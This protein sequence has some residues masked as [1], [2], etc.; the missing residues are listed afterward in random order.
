VSKA[1]GRSTLELF[2]LYFNLKN[3]ELKPHIIIGDNNQGIKTVA[4]NEFSI[5]YV[6]VGSAE[7]AIR[8]KSPI[9]LLPINRIV[10]ST[11]NVLKEFFPVS[12]PLNLITKDV[13]IGL[14][15]SFIDFVLSKA[16]R[17]YIVEQFFVPLK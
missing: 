16:A 3:S 8:E 10:A 1:E 13:P 12:R 5:A 14:A 7:G 4:G 9:K 6:S 17:P 15:K 11:D 2:L